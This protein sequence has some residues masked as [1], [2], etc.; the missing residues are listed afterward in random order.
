M[1]NQFEIFYMISGLTI[2][3]QNASVNFY[4]V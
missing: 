2:H 1:Y 3:E 4:Y